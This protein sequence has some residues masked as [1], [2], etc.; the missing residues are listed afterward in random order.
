VDGFFFRKQCFNKLHSKTRYIIWNILKDK[1][2]TNCDT[3]KVASNVGF[4]NAAMASNAVNNPIENGQEAADAVIQNPTIVI[5]DTSLDGLP[6][7]DVPHNTGV[8]APALFFMIICASCVEKHFVAKYVKDVIPWNSFC[9]KHFHSLSR[10]A[11]LKKILKRIESN[12]EEVSSFK[13]AP[14]TPFSIVHFLSHPENGYCI[15]D[16]HRSKLHPNVKVTD[17]EGR[18]MFD[19][20]SAA[21]NVEYR[22]SMRNEPSCFSK[23]I[24]SKVNFIIGYASRGSDFCTPLHLMCRSRFATSAAIFVLLKANHEA[25]DLQYLP[26]SIEGT[27]LQ[28]A[29]SH[30]V[31]I[32]PITMYVCHCIVIDRHVMSAFLDACS[33]STATEMYQKSADFELF[34]LSC[35]RARHQLRSDRNTTHDRTSDSSPYLMAL[36]VA[37]VVLQHRTNFL[38]NNYSLLDSNGRFRIL[39][40]ICIDCHHVMCFHRCGLIEQFISKTLI[41]SK[42]E[43]GNTPLHLL[44]GIDTRS[45]QGSQISEFITITC[46]R[47]MERAPNVLFAVNKAG[48]NILHIALAANSC[49][50]QTILMNI[51]KEDCK[52]LTSV[53]DP[54]EKL[55]PFMLAAK[56]DLPTSIIYMMLRD[57]FRRARGLRNNPLVK[58]LRT[59]EAI[60]KNELE[61]EKAENLRIKASNEEKMKL[62]RDDYEKQLLG[63]KTELLN[64]K[65]INRKNRDTTTNFHGDKTNEKKMVSYEYIDL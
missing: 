36:K 41:E 14:N 49:C 48:K 9:G 16:S 54:S 55:L 11:L 27:K 17:T 63:L 25:V 15:H 32:F 40:A 7:Q 59:S 64:V 12:P 45:L 57:D 62:L 31:R 47:L 52:R 30:G 44:V 29:S 56:S 8:S 13:M 3:A 34:S 53:W 35:L 65:R 18:L 43:F 61:Y 24:C 23:L 38:A 6:T 39:H 37:S 1:N 22:R 50:T 28:T 4:S 2:R 10:E 26:V 20:F 5:D 60:L 46:R 21:V 58:N 33:M 51:S 19:V 42:D